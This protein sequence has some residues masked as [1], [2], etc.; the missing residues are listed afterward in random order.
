[1]IR[2]I[3]SIRTEKPFSENGLATHYVPS[4]RLPQLL[5]QLTAMEDPTMDR[6]NSAIEELYDDPSNDEVTNA[7]VGDVRVAVDT[8]FA[9]NSVEEIFES[10]QSMGTENGSVGDWARQTLAVMEMRSPTSLK[11]ALAAIRKGKQLTLAESL[12]ME[13]GIATAFL[14]RVTGLVSLA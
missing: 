4:R 1:M 3:P 10:L 8:A 6:I 7:I 12:R 11:V 2:S 9:H 13:L 14:V 5:A